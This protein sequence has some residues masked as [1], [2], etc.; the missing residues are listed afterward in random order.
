M[1]YD[2]ILVLN[3]DQTKRLVDMPEVIEAVEGGFREYS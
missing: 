2:E 1:S 3:K